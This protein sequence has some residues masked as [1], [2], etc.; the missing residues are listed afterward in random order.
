MTTINA[1]IP[2]KTPIIWR[3]ISPDISLHYTFHFGEFA[4][5]ASIFNR[6]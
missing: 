4:L 1:K 6:F 2:K 5:E 3:A